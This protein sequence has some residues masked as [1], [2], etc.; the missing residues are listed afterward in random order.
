[1]KN[2]KNN[3]KNT[4]INLSN[5]TFINTDEL[6]LYDT[7]QFIKEV[8]VLLNDY[9]NIST[10]YAL[11]NRPQIFIM[12]DYDEYNYKKGFIED[13]RSIM[14]GHEIISYQDLNDT[15]LYAL[16]NKDEYLKKFNSKKNDLINKYYNLDN[17]NSCKLFDNFINT[18]S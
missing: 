4:I 16:N 6:H 10:D 5:I 18:L 9:S 12:P 11:L 13:Y 1:M 7:N 8:D 3:K 2:Y 14:P 17:K 15:I